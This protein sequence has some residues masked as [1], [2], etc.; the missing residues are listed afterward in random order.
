[1]KYQIIASDLDGTLLNDQAQVSREN[2]DAICELRRHGIWL[3]PCSGRTFSEIPA[4]VREHPGVRYLIHS[5][6]AVVLDRQ[7]GQRLLRGIPNQVGCEILDMLASYETHLT[8]RHLGECYVDAACQK[9]SDWEY[10]NLCEAHCVVVRDYAVR[11]QDFYGF[12]RAAD[13]AEVFS[14]F[15]HDYEEKLA[16]KKRLEELGCLRVAEASEYNLEIFHKD[17]GKGNA[18]Y[19]LADMLG[20]ARAAT[21]GVGDSDN[22]NSMLRAAGLGLA[23]ANACD[24]LKAIADQIICSNEEHVLPYIV[25]HYV[26]E[27]ERDV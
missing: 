14:A 4:A 16:C 12:A 8:M 3:V 13:N 9:Q 19:D 26:D 21:I 2:L 27:K 1:M 15:F 7:T 24:S 10:Y 20:I 17:A 23:V 11:L 25:S 6:G 5:N 18:L 22:D